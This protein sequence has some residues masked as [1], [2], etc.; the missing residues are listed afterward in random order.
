METNLEYVYS[1]VYYL[2]SY[3]Q[4]VIL[5]VIGVPGAIL[6]GNRAVLGKWESGIGSAYSR[7]EID[8]GSWDGGACVLAW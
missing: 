6:A 5:S 2:L 3:L 1:L 8:P 7:F 4:Q